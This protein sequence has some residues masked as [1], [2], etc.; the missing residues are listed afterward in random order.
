MKSQSKSGMK[1]IVLC[2]KVPAT[3]EKQQ[4]Q[5]ISVYGSL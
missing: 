3:K 1:R 5:K 2:K 4:Q